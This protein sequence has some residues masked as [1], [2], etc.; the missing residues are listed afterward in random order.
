MERIVESQQGVND[1]TGLGFGSFSERK[2]TFEDTE[3]DESSRVFNKFAPPLTG[4]FMPPRPDY[5]DPDTGERV[6]LTSKTKLGK[7]VEN[8]APII[9]EWVSDSEDECEIKVKPK[10]SCCNCGHD[11]KKS[12][13]DK[14]TNQV[15]KNDD[16]KT[17]S[18]KNSKPYNNNQRSWNNNNRNRSGLGYYERR[19]CYECGSYNHLIRFC[20]IK[21][22]RLAQKA[23][24]NR[25]RRDRYN[26]QR[27]TDPHPKKDF[28]PRHVL[29]R[30]GMKEIG[31]EKPTIAVPNGTA[32]PV[33]KDHPKPYKSFHKRKPRKSFD[34]NPSKNFSYYRK[35]VYTLKEESD[36]GSKKVDTAIEKSDTA[37]EKADLGDKGTA[38]KA[39]AGCVVR[40][41]QEIVD[42]VSKLNSASMVWKQF[43]YIDA[44]GRSKSV[45]AWVPLRN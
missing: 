3:K 1:K 5:I 37:G 19:A 11:N 7:K 23:N 38:V 15:K 32:R 16:T 42:Q 6:E 45:M 26:K 22:R 34:T 40:P 27:F 8:S 41:D 25:S 31:S 44:Q 21:R 33:N 4:N 35:F 24:W 2:F 39:S 18:W 17:D 43:D 9:E 12:E 13:T 30:S 28:V 10:K 14:K 36:T 20:E 29:L